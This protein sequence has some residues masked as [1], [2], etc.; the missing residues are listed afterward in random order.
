MENLAQ[1]QP[2]QASELRDIERLHEGLIELATFLSQLQKTLSKS[3]KL[4]ASIDKKARKKLKQVSK[5]R[6]KRE[7]RCK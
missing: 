3:M 2:S 6:S 1:S 7:K 4:V 5:A